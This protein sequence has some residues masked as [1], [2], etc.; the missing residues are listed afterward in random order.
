MNAFSLWLTHAA[1]LTLKETRQILRDKSAI[2]LGVFMPLML[3]ILFGYGLSF[4]VRNIRLGVVDMARTEQTERITASLVSNESFK[5]TV[6]AARGE[7]LK[8]L[9]NFEIEA[10][11]V[12]EKQNTSTVSRQIVVDGIDAPRATMIVN[13][14]SGAAG[15][16]M[17]GESDGAG[18]IVVPRIWFNESVISTWY[19]VPG[20][21]VIV[22]TLTG[23]M[24]TSLV[25]A[26]EWER[27]TME[28]MIATPASPSAIL[29]SKTFPY[30]CLGMLGWA[31]CMSAAYFLYEV[32]VR[33]SFWII[34][35]S[36]ALYL[37]MGLG[38]GL[39]ISG[40]TRSQFL[41]SQVTVLV[42]FL[43]AVI[44]SG[45][46]FDLRSAPAW[47]DVMAHC[48]PP[49]YYLEVLKVGFLTGGMGRSGAQEHG[50]SVAFCGGGFCCF[51]P[52]VSEEVAK[53]TNPLRVM[54]DRSARFRALLHKE[55]LT[56]L[57]DRTSR[58]ILVGPLILYV[59]LF[60]YV[61]TFN[62]DYAPYALLDM[63]K[64]RQSA[65][66]IRA[67][68]QSAVFDRVMTLQNTAQ[69]APAIDSGKALV[70]MVI[71]QDYAENLTEGKPAQVQVIIDG[72]N[73]TTA[74]LAAGYLS[75]IA[76][77][78]SGAGTVFESIRYLYNPNNLTQWF[79]L[80]ALIM[81]LSMLQIMVL[82]ALS[83]AREREMGTFE[84]L[85]VTPFMTG[86]LL[87]SKAVVPILIGIFQGTLIFL[88]SVFWF[89][90]PL[91]GSILKI[92]AVMAVFVLAVV[93]LGLAISAYSKTMQQGLL[94]AFVTLVP[95][96][97]LSGL[98]T[99]VDNMPAWVQA[100]TWADPLRFAL[101]SV[102]RIYLADASW[103]H[104]AQTMIPTAAVA[105]VTL[106]FA[107]HY[108]K[109]RL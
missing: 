49:A 94:I 57:K 106:P 40:V 71:G 19:L 12:F 93:G 44:L 15:I 5:T 2:L 34:L 32:P 74:Q 33:G 55:M 21:F 70:V 72:R 1:A 48:L 68:D 95:M 54:L 96:V 97:L 73:S 8:A 83:V 75:I 17:A 63:S 30:F 51:L 46:I 92:Y 62:L 65:E 42:S 3:I 85:L 79:I 67:V 26:R 13:A 16:A 64:T 11:A 39:M 76:G 104:I 37:L 103:L 61:A 107:Y 101:L 27:G 108:F 58:M 18:T 6:Y 82:S 60:G 10:L 31:L 50:D 81:M 53:M 25:L 41:A 9:E 98:F 84:Q 14:V 89:E 7:A 99:P 24:M 91:M 105:A 90:V 36:S 38:L 78:V 43:P 80:P 45:F 35:G 20:L 109:K 87:A 102:R 86:E 100:I 4:D 88:I 59:I 23:C 28:A 66:L 52:S 69:I 22:L 29:V 56:T 77:N 47:A